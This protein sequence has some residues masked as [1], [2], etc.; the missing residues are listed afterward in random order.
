MSRQERCEGRSVYSPPVRCKAADHCE[1]TGEEGW[2]L[3]LVYNGDI[4]GVVLWD[5]EDDPLCF[6]AALLLIQESNWRPL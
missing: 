1:R 4:W 6:R 5:N 3:A 2:L